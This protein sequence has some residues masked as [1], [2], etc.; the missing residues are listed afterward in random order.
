MLLKD[1]RQ[2]EMSKGNKIISSVRSDISD[3][4]VAFMLA[5]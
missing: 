1:D 4:N 5:L 3:F 2:H